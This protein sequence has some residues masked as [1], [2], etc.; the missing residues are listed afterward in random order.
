MSERRNT[1]EADQAFCFVHS[2]EKGPVP[3][4]IHIAFG[5]GFFWHWKLP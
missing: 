4:A 2:H 5:Q 1:V 3:Q